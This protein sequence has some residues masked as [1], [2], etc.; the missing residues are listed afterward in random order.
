MKSGE[1]QANLTASLTLMLGVHEDK[2]GGLAKLRATSPCL[3][4][5]PAVLLTSLEGLDLPHNFILAS[6][7]R[8]Q[9]ILNDTHVLIFKT[10]KYYFIRQRNL[11]EVMKSRTTR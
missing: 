1:H 11:A 4:F 8:E 2:E 3:V 5:L 9:R 10:R 6:L 7:G